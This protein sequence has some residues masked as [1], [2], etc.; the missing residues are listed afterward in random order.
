MKILKIIKSAKEQLM[1][2]G[3][4]AT[5]II[6]QNTSLIEEHLT[7]RPIPSLDKGD[8]FVGKIFEMD[9]YI[10]ESVKKDGFYLVDCNNY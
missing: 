3:V 10:D 1:T 8:G 9:V 7:H 5:H 4:E 2:Q 6:V